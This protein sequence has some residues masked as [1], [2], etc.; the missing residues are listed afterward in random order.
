MT[1]KS[2]GLSS[3]LLKAI[4]DSGYAEPTP[5]QKSDSYDIEWVGY[6]CL[7]SNRHG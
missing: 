1:F 2:L 3:P 5:V 4:Q 6:G 7:C